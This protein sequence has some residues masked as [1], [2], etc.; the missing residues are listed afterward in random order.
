ME[1]LENRR[2]R[3]IN[4]R[5]LR[6][7]GLF[8][9]AA[10][11][12]GRG[13]IQGHM[14]GVGALN[15][16]ELL[17]AIGATEQAMQLATI[18][19]IL[20]ALETCALP[21]FAL[22]L[23]EGIQHTSDKKAYFLRVLGLALTCEIPYN[24]AV[25]V[26]ILD[27]STRNPVF[28]LV[29]AMA[30]IL[31]YGMYDAPGIKNKLIKLFVTVAALVWCNMLTIEYG[32]PMVVIAA[33]LWA[34]RGKPLYRNFAGAAAAICCTAFNPFFL[35]APMGFMAVHFYNGEHA[36]RNGSNY[37]YLYYPIIL[38]AAFSLGILL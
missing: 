30:M 11:I 7:W 19:L 13:T 14:L 29:V 16:Q 5:N 33:V 27:F 26:K 10:G 25:G 21:I 18:S 28:S 8:F 24:L 17:S 9:A 1:R 34:F 22:L 23:V 32:G 36:E 38:I 12:I 4:A 37:N 35:A 20:Q 3:G 15:G 6:A 2:P 31:L